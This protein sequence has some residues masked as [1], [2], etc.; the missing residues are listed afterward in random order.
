[1]ARP[2]FKPTPA[3]RAKVNTLASIGIPQEQIAEFLGLR[4]PKTVRRH[5]R[6][7]LS[8]GNAEAIA[9]VAQVCLEMAESQKYPVVTMFWMNTLGSAFSAETK[10]IPVLTKIVAIRKD[11]PPGEE[12]Q[13]RQRADGMWV[14]EQDV[15]PPLSKRPNPQSRKGEV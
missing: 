10:K 15:G 8:K 3:Q 2:R 4:S 1:M 6:K 14:S 5:F 13:Y 7:E 12:D 9:R 11:V